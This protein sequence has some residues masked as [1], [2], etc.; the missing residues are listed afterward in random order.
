[1]RVNIAEL[2]SAVG[3]ISDLVVG[4]K[5]VPGVMLD[6]SSDG[7][8][9]VCYTDGHKS[10]IEELHVELDENDV[11]DKI[12]V[13]YDMFNRAIANCQ[14]SGNI[15]VDECKIEYLNDKLIR[16]SADQ[17]YDVT[18]SE[19]NVEQTKRLSTKKMDLAFVKPGSDMKSAIFTRM[20][21]D[22]IFNADTT[23]VFNKKEFINAL[24]KTTTEKGRPVYISNK[25]Q[26][27]FVANQV[28][29]TSVP[30]SKLEV[31]DERLAEIK[32]ELQSQNNFTEE[33]YAEAVNKE[34]DRIH[35]SI[36]IQYNNAKS[37]IGI[38]NKTKS[39]E[40]Y[41][42]TK[43]RF[44]NIFIDNEDETVGIWFEMATASRVHIETLQRF[45]SIPY[46]S[47]QITFMREFL[48]DIVK[49]ALNVTNSEKTVFSFSKNEEGTTEIEFSAGSSNASVADS[50]KVVCDKVLDSAG[51]ITERKFNISLKILSEMINQIKTNWLAFDLYISDD[52]TTYLR[53]G[54][55]NDNKL[56][57]EYTKARRKTE[58]LCTAQGIAFDCNSTPTPV[59]LMLNYRVDVLDTKQFTML[60]K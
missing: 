16:L 25:M 17:L 26:G 54:E 29:T 56:A 47:Y 46:T 40:V 55:I 14:P 28:H 36:A 10:L 57:T 18:D 2:T 23:D 38:L 5:Q 1:M 24:T 32:S 8:L 60:S 11:V 3:K 9:K 15:K 34:S 22:D 44:C 6:L 41:V 37:L 45:D 52:G 27:M 7:L 53:I 21:Y 49:S 13:S 33:A 51:D 59:E 31:S 58:E 30:I 50:Y 42:Y 35:F 48:A 20:K 12:V 43:D 39:D 19:G 4:D